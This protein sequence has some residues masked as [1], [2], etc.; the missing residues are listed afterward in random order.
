VANVNQRAGKAINAEARKLSKETVD[1]VSARR[2]LVDNLRETGATLGDDGVELSQSE[3]L[4]NAKAILDDVVKRFDSADGNALKLHRLK[5]FIDKKVS[6]GKQL[7]GGLD[8]DAQ[9][10]LKRFRRDIDSVLDSNFANYKQANESYSETRDAIDKFAKLAGKTFDMD[11]PRAAERIGTLS[12]RVFSNAQS[13]DDVINALDGLD[14]IA[15]KNGLNVGDDLIQLAR[16]DEELKRVF[17]PLT[18]TSTTF[19]GEAGKAVV[20]AAT[21][22]VVRSAINAG[23]RKAKELLSVAPDDEKLLS[24][25]RELLS[26]SPA[27]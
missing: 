18:R 16:F 13:K 27:Q 12:R 20:D 8:S 10:I 11:N 17:K 5:R 1:A 7:E 6:Y 4:P 14:E 24:T 26:D 2:G 22:G 19:R 3:I 9:R 15:Q 25:L 23:G 21:E